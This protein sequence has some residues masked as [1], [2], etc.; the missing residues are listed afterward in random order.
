LRTTENFPTT[1]TP[2]AEA[3][4]EILAGKLLN[5]FVVDVIQGEPAPRRT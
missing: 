2:I 1:G 5:Q 4:R 3:R